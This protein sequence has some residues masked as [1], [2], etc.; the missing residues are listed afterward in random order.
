MKKA[1][2]TKRA[3]VSSSSSSGGGP[4]PKSKRQRFG[5][6][7][8]EYSE[9]SDEDVRLLLRKQDDDMKRWLNGK[10]LKQKAEESFNKWMKSQA[11]E[12]GATTSMKKKA[13][14]MKKKKGIDSLLEQI[15]IFQYC[16]PPVR[17]ITMSTDGPIKFTF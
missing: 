11:D 2:A 17:N 15:D 5:S 16:Q 12:A 8:R 13:P 9:Y 7:A 10:T 3:S 1:V 14:V 6:P 4:A